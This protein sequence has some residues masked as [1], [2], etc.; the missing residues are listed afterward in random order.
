MTGASIK[1]YFWTIAWTVRA[2]WSLPPPG[3]AATMNSTGREGAHG[4]EATGPAQPIAPSS[5]AG[6]S[7]PSLT[8]SLAWLMCGTS[9]PAT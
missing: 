4:P 6:M 9:A 3:P 5:A 1:P 7:R 8:Y 2:S